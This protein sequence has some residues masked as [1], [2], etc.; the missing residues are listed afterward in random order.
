[1]SRVHVAA[2][3]QSGAL[4]DVPMD[5]SPLVGSGNPARDVLALWRERQVWL[6]RVRPKRTLPDLWGFGEGGMDS[7]TAAQ[8][9]GF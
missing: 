2:N 8:F 4:F 6:Y 3:G 1:V 7:V 5:R 9:F